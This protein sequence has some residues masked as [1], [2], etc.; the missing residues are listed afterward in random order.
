MIIHIKGIYF[1]TS[2]DVN[3]NCLPSTSCYV[4]LHMHYLTYYVKC[5]MED[6]AC[7]LQDVYKVRA[8]TM[9]YYTWNWTYVHLYQT[10]TK[11]GKPK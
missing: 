3:R 8:R 11:I 9:Q 4:T 7:K 6:I 5:E 1:E 10:T 2:K